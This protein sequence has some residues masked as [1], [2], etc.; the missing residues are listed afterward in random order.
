[1]ARI[2]S[3]AIRNWPCSLMWLTTMRR[4]C[5]TL[6]RSLCG[7]IR[8]NTA[9]RFWRNRVQRCRF[10]PLVATATPIT[11]W[12]N[13]RW[14]TTAVCRRA[15][16]SKSIPIAQRV[17]NWAVW[18]LLIS[19]I[20]PSRERLRSFA[21][22][23]VSTTIMFMVVQMCRILALTIFQCVGKVRSLRQWMVLI[24]SRRQVTM[25]CAFGWTT[26]WWLTNG[27]TNRRRLTTQVFIWRKVKSRP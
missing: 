7:T 19:T 5:N 1:M 9:N 15:I 26:F 6:G 8:T 3:R 17:C 16:P 12:L 11:I 2:P 25:V 27:L 21:A 10:R 22:K 4:V 13:W 20:R 14:R 24:R 18:R 23:R